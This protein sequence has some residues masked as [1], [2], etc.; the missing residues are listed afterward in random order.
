MSCGP[1]SGIASR[2]ESSKSRIVALSMIPA[3]RNPWAALWMASKASPLNLCLVVISHL[4]QIT[5]FN[6]AIEPR[7]VHP[8]VFLGNTPELDK[9]VWIDI[10]SIFLCIQERENLDNPSLGQYD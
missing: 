4:Q 8:G 9:F 6:Q 5:G 1:I 7:S 10:G 3:R 2:Q